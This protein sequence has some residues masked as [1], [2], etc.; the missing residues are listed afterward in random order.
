MGVCERGHVRS[1]GGEGGVHRCC[2]AWGV[3]Q[4]LLLRPVRACVCVCVFVLC[5]CVCMCVYMRA[6]VCM[7]VCV[8][9]CVC[10]CV[11]VCAYGVK[12]TSSERLVRP[13]CWLQIL[14]HA[15]SVLYILSSLG[16]VKCYMHAQKKKWIG[17]MTACE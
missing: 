12:S 2:A 9:M 15:A 13:G 10:T 3:L 7:C 5:V 6:C 17:G 16:R 8:R 1:G 4:W 14:C 11:Y